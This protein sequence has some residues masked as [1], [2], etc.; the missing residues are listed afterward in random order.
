MTDPNNQ[1]D[2]I[3]EWML[4]LGATQPSGTVNGFWWHKSFGYIQPTVVIFFYWQ[5][6]EA[7]KEQIMQDFFAYSE[8]IDDSEDKFITVRD[9][10]LTT[11]KEQ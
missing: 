11:L 3:R 7:R 5:M 6:L 1:S 10:L 8:E 2:P 4:S 9:D